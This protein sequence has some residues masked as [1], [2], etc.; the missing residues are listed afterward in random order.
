MTHHAGTRQQHLRPHPRDGPGSGARSCTSR[1]TT[2]AS[3]PRVAPTDR[4]SIR[5]RVGQAL[6][7][8]GS[9]L[10]DAGRHPP[11]VADRLTVMADDVARPGTGPGRRADDLRRGDAQGAVRPAPAPDPG[12]DDRRPRRGLHGQAPGG[13]PRGLADQ[14]LPPRQPARRTRAHPAG[15]DPG[16]LRDHRDELPHRP[17]EREARSRPAGR[18]QPRPPRHAHDRLRRR[19]RRHRARHPRRRHRPRRG[20]R[21]APS[22]R[23][24]PRAWPASRRNAPRVPGAPQGAPGELRRRPHGR[25]GRALRLRPRAST[26]WPACRPTTTTEDPS[27]G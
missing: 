23:S 25:R 26:R 21:P 8:L 12:A 5:V 14:A 6:I 7:D 22:G 20:H 1:P 2:S 19:P 15:R 9:S 13:G 17:A 3:P 10:V 16:R 11:A 4:P 24:S 27:D 18:R